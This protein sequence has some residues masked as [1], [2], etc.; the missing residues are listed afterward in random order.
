M[1]VN[2]EDH[3]VGPIETVPG[4]LS[5]NVEIRTNCKVRAFPR[6]RLCRDFSTIRVNSRRT[7]SARNTEAGDSHPFTSAALDHLFWVEG[8]PVLL[9]LHATSL[10]EQ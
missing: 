10:E 4:K 7:T 5:F 3:F 1:V 6:P 8:E 2:V 9:L